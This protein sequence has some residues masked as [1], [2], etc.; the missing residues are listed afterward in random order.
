[1]SAYQKIHRALLRAFKYTC[2][3]FWLLESRYHLYAYRVASHSGYRSLIMLQCEYRGRHEYSNLLSA[4]DRLEGC[5][6]SHLG[7]SE[8][9]VTAQ[10]TIHRHRAHHIL[11]YF[12]Y[13]N[14]LRFSLLVAE[15]RF[16]FVLKLRVRR[17]SKSRRSLSLS[18]YFDKILSYILN[19]SLSSRLLAHPF[20]ATHNR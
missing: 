19:R 2:S 4:E 9:N 6:Q 11:F 15:L 1:M 14:Q 8:T 10:K 18:I 5:S 17:E 13:R 16:K 7:L 20:A 3:L 12:L